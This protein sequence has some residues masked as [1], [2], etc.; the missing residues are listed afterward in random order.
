L[1]TLK[2]WP[3][4]SRVRC[5]DIPFTRWDSTREKVSAWAP[6]LRVRDLDRIYMKQGAILR[7]FTGNGQVGSRKIHYIGGFWEKSEKK[8][9][10]G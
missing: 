3:R 6:D 8:G 5:L 9:E 10:F 7:D 4:L 1:G 2:S